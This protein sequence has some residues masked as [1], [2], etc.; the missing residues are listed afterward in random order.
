MVNI[1]DFEKIG[2]DAKEIDIKEIDV[3]SKGKET[4]FEEIKIKKNNE[5]S[6]SVVGKFKKFWNFLKEDSWPSFIVTL[7]IAFIIIK[8][9]FFPLLS[10]VTGSVMP[11][12]IVESCSMYHTTNLENIIE[13]NIYSDYGIGFDNASKW[14]FKTG[15]NKGDII[16]VVSSKNIKVG[17]VI[18][19]NSGGATAHPIIHRVISINSDGT[20]TTKGDHNSGILPVEKNIQQEQIVGKALFRVPFLG[21]VKLVFFEATRPVSERGFCE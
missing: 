21:W 2:K 8:F 19:F 7:I 20:Y 1:K 17:D 15:M 6:F 5:K 4:K 13:N 11:L 9:V 14:N 12:V 10:L 18:I 3:K 16:F